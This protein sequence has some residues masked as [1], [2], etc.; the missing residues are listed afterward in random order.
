MADGPSLFD[1]RPIPPKKPLTPGGYRIWRA[2]EATRERRQKAT[3]DR[4]QEIA[5]L[6]GTVEESAAFARMSA[7]EARFE[8]DMAAVEANQMSS[9]PP[10]IFELLQTN[11]GQR[12]QFAF[13]RQGWSIVVAPLPEPKQPEPVRS[14][15]PAAT[16]LL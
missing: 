12:C 16:Q 6:L 13:F 15:L 10:G 4:S 2:E 9:M 1:W 7:R 11:R 5:L 3:D 14:V 8:A